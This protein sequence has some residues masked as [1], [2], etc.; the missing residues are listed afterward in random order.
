MVLPLDSSLTPKRRYMGVDQHQFALGQHDQAFVVV[1]RHLK[2]T[3]DWQKIVAGRNS[4]VEDFKVWDPVYLKQHRRTDK[5]DNTGTPYYRIKNQKGPISF[6]GAPSR[7]WTTRR[8]SAFSGIWRWK[9]LVL[10]L[11]RS[12]VYGGWDNY[13]KNKRLLA[14]TAELPQSRKP[15]GYPL[16]SQNTNPKSSFYSKSYVISRHTWKLPKNTDITTWLISCVT[17]MVEV[18][19]HTQKTIPQRPIFPWP[20][21]SRYQRTLLPRSRSYLPSVFNWPEVPLN[22]EF[23][24]LPQLVTDLIHCESRLAGHKLGQ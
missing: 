21:H 18:G 5:L 12:R 6:C 4:K 10:R 24:Y 9:R 22:P 14:T 15:S 16:G 1:H 2:K 19:S 7:R 11:S 3:K 8:C 17:G 20:R 23:G 13:K